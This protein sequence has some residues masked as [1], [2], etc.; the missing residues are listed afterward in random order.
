MHVLINNARH[1][2]QNDAAKKKRTF[3][4]KSLIKSIGL[5]IDKHTWNTPEWLWM[6]KRRLEQKKNLRKKA[7]A[8]N[9]NLIEIE[10]KCTHTPAHSSSVKIG[11]LV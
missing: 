6:N 2:S 10:H 11:N 8:K 5:M 9:Q 7:S 3:L 4:E 1:Q